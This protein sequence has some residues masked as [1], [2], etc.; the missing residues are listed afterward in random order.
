[1]RVQLYIPYTHAVLILS[2][3]TALFAFPR[4]HSH[5]FNSEPILPRPTAAYHPSISIRP[6]AKHAQRIRRHA[7]FFLLPPTPNDIRQT[8]TCFIQHHQ[9]I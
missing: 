5:A 3:R 2:Q 4:Q 7:R 6:A 8:Q 1:M 9:L